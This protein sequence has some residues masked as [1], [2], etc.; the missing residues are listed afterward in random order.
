MLEAIQ[1]G[2]P[3]LSS[4]VCSMP[5]HHP[6]ALKKLDAKSLETFL[7]FMHEKKATNSNFLLSFFFF[8]WHLRSDTFFL[9]KMTS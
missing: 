3:Q 8:F 4:A 7:T 9:G 1:A 5:C 2:Q 6:L